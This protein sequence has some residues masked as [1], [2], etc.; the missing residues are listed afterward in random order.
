MLRKP[1]E[2]GNLFED[3]ERTVLKL[4]A[5]P[6]V[7][8]GLVPVVCG[9]SQGPCR[10]VWPADCILRSSS[11]GAT[12][13]VKY[14]IKTIGDVFGGKAREPNPGPSGAKYETTKKTLAIYRLP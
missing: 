2:V 5:G 10:Q 4:A 1:M 6:V 12:S 13:L 14:Q 7:E 9:Q 8:R 3:V 11:E